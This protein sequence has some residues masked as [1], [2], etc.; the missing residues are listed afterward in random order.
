[1]AIGS[2]LCGTLLLWALAVSGCSL[3]KFAADRVG[4]IASGSSVYMRG[5]WDYE[6]ARQGMAA[7]IMQLESM[8]SV[9]PDNEELTL[10]LV[11]TYVGYGFGWLE[12]DMGKARNAGRFVEADRLRA[13]GELVYRRA[14]DLAV[15]VMRYRDA[16]IDAKLLEKPAQFSRYLNDHYKDPKA[17][18]APVFWTAIAWGSLLNLTEQVD[19]AVD[20]PTIKALIEHSAKLDPGFQ[21][22]GALMFLGGFYAQFPAEFGGSPEKGKAYFER[23]LKLTGRRAHVVQLNYA[24]LYALTVGDQALFAALL[25][26]IMAA[27]DRGSDVRLSNKI[28]RMHA[29]V[30]LS[31]TSRLQ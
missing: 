23:A 19:L 22:A 17:D 30:L 10:A 26:E 29:E 27:D 18:V 25:N 9:S 7:A 1:M 2:R 16:A 31:D 21:S 24:R 13:R 20:L 15:A 14:R 5:F 11:S 28:A 12:V 8:H 4:S 3:N 6:I